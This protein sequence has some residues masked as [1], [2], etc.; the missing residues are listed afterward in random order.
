MRLISISGSSGV[1]KTTLSKLIECVLGSDNVVSLSGD[2]LHRWERADPAWS[3]FTHLNPTANDLEM[4]HSHIESLVNGNA[5]TRRFYNHDTGRFDDPV[6]IEPKKYLVYEGL[7]AL[8]NDDTNQMADLLIFVDTDEMLK[9]EWKVK[10]DTKK[11]GYTEAQVIDTMRRRKVDEI[12]YI[13]PQRD[14]ADIVV[15]FTK[16]KDSSIAFDYVC[17]RNSQFGFDLMKK[18]KE[19][20]DSLSDFMGICKWLSLDQSLTQGSGGNVSVKTNSGMIVKSSGFKMSDINLHHGYSVCNIDGVLMPEFNSEET[21]NDFIR[22]SMKFGSGRPSMETGFHARISDRVV[23]HTHPV[24]LNTLL[25]SQEA[26]AVIR[27]LFQDLKYEFVEYTTPG[28]E[29][30]NRISEGGIIFLENHGLIVSAETSEDAIRLTESIN[31]RCKRWLGSHVESFVDTDGELSV[32]SSP[33]F[34]DAA[35]L[36]RE[37]SPTNNYILRLMMGA[38][39]TPKF[40]DDSQVKHLNEMASE[41][42]RKALS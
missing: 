23:I 34:P 21:Y 4:G 30:V 13:S 35:V 6:T 40:L 10:R 26:K 19:F 36:P 5:I 18:V 28:H 25:C 20:H 11:R 22:E 38:C 31:D 33:L 9:T 1:G 14:H 15:K 8:Y 17:M 32:D 41:K 3:K 42:Y 29:L 16:A 2:D 7:H 39:L 27:G 37:M 24:H 12:A